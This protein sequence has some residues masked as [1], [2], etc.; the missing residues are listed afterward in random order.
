VPLRRRRDAAIAA[1]AMGLAAAVAIVLAWP[2]SPADDEVR[3]KGT[4]IVG[5]FVAHGDAIRR[6]APHEAVM[7][8]D[9]V[10]LFTT[11]YEPVW[12]TA[13]GDDATGSRSVYVEPR[14][15]DPGREQIV[16]LSVELDGT[17]GSEVV[18][19]VFCTMRIHPLAVIVDAPP[20]GC[21]VDRFTLVKV[22]R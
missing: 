21:T 12:F 11:T 9:R 1:I 14:Q 17:L 10:E 6:G 20:R 16:P 4:P 22:P 7:P 19:G 8:G 13:F 18:T 3:T 15:L 5:F 2:R